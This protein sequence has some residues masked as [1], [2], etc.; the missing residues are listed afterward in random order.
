MLQYADAMSMILLLSK[1]WMD[2]GIGLFLQPLLQK[3]PY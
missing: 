1:N 2:K 3:Q